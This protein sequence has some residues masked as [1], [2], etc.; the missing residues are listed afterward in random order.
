MP[1]SFPVEWA[2]LIQEARERHISHPCANRRLCAAEG[3]AG[4]KHLTL[5]MNN[6][7]MQCASFEIADDPVMQNCLSNEGVV[8]WIDL[9]T[10]IDGQ[11]LVWIGPP[12]ASWIWIAR[13]SFGRS[14]G[15]TLGD[16][17]NPHT[18]MHNRIAEFVALTMRTAHTLNL[19]V[20]MEQPLSSIMPEH[21]AVG[22]ALRD[23][24]CEK[25]AIRLGDVGSPSQKPLQLW[26]SAPWIGSLQTLAAEARLQPQFQAP[27][28]T[29]AT[30]KGGA[31]TG[32]RAELAESAAYP[33]FFCKCPA[34]LHREFTEGRNVARVRIKDGVLVADVSRKRLVGG[35][36][37]SLAGRAI[38]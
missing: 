20:V 5:A 38:P 16:L 8:Y 31:V 36:L 26:T 6:C 11:G 37:K 10:S 35:G 17:S 3:F 30:R 4:S 27:T 34:F 1:A 25:Q 12:C 7:G 28:Q 15:N 21:P 23:V 18:V 14:Q 33:M 2:G 19:I 22:A 9:L 24:N 32:R 13:S 29:L